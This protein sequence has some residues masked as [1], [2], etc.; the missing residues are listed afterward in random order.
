MLSVKQGGIKYHFRVF[1]MTRPG[2]DPRSPR[3]L[4]NT[5]IGLVYGYKMFK[6]LNRAF[7]SSSK[8]FMLVYKDKQIIIQNNFFRARVFVYLNDLIILNE[9]YVNDTSLVAMRPKSDILLSVRY[10]ATRPHNAAILERKK[11]DL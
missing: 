9:L 5:L 1:G 2:I 4:A 6:S 7:K 8:F 10:L 11:K 3:P